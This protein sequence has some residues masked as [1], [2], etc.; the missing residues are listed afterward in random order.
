M[1][2]GFSRKALKDVHIRDDSRILPPERGSYDSS[3]SAMASTTASSSGGSGESNSTRRPSAGC[4]KAS[5]HACRNG[6][7]SR[8]TA[9]RL[10]PDA[11]V[12]AAVGRVADDRVAD[13]AQMHA[14]LMRTAGGDRD[15]DERHALE[16]PRE[17]HARHR[18]ARPPRP[19]RHLLP[20]LRI[21]ADRLVDAPPGVHDTPD[22]RDV[23]LLDFAVAE[24][25][26]TAP[27][28]PCRAWRR[29]SVPRCRDRDGARCPGAARRRR[30]SG[31]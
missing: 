8:I 2:S 17:G 18:A 27:G 21:A 7:S 16:V 22:E 20:V 29:P 5:R 3:C 4:V 25:A 31:P 30:R 10:L 13:G 9:R 23:F 26:A 14:D 24:T 15:L 12:H 19:R 11:A 6:R 28:A 1:A